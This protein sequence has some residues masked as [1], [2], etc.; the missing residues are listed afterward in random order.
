LSLPR[1]DARFYLTTTNTQGEKND[2]ETHD[3]DT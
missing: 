2:D 3:R 1:L